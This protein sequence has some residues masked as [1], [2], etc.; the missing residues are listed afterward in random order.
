MTIIPKNSS[1]F[2]RN[3]VLQVLLLIFITCGFS[4]CGRSGMESLPNVILIVMDTARAE[5]FSCYGYHRPTSP[6]IDTFAQ[7]A[8]FYANAMASSPW[9]VP[10][11][12]S[13]FTGKDPFEHGAHRLNPKKM[14]HI[15]S[16]PLHEKHTTLAEAFAAEGYA[17]G[18]FVANST[19]INDRYQMDQGFQEFRSELAVSDSINQWTYAWLDTLSADRFFLFINYMDTHAPYNAKP[20]PGFLEEPPPHDNGELFNE[21]KYKYLSPRQ[22][23]KKINPVKLRQTVTDQYDTAIANLDEQIG[24]LIN[25]LKDRDLYDESLIVLTSDHGEVFGE[26]QLVSHGLDVY[27]QLLWVPLVIKDPG[28]SNPRKIDDVISTSDIPRIILSQFPDKLS[29]KYQVAFPNAPGEH[30]II[31]E[32]YY[33]HS[34]LLKMRHMRKKYTRIRT[35]I[36]D[37]PYKYIHSSDGMHELYNI[38]QDRKEATD[39]LA[40]KPDIAKKLAGL[41]R[42]HK[43]SRTHSDEIIEQK[44]LTDKEIKQLKSLGYIGE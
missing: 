6:T 23:R 10:T 32:N 35:V 42:D 30:P 24:A 37:W 26:H 14:T 44:P 39:L 19:Y 1:L 11:H 9:T 38:A 2:R 12:A 25:Y 22:R 41:I 20:R 17:T 3:P 27:Q 28:Q 34:W 43:N 21:L 15:M 4:S 16:N 18:A 8:T 29:S 36:F 31:A 40:A 13:I 7:E 33:A 5:N